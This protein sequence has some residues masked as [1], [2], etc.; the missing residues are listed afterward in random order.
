MF[1]CLVLLSPI[2]S[3]S[4]FISAM[5]THHHDNYNKQQDSGYCIAVTTKIWRRGL[6][7]TGGEA[8]LGFI[9]ITGQWQM[10]CIL[11]GDTTWSWTK[12]QSDMEGNLN[13]VSFKR[14]RW[15][16]KKILLTATKKCWIPDSRLTC[17][18]PTDGSTMATITFY[19]SGE[20][21]ILSLFFFPLLSVSFEQ[22][23]VCPTMADLSFMY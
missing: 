11:S 16:K 20:N 23:I 1:F 12:E 9:S 19:S 3:I 15:K 5:L 2:L 4:F 21:L 18:Q 7:G 13:L 17:H 22:F 8:H 14:R 10:T 6:G